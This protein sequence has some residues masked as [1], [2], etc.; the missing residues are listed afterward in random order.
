MISASANSAQA[1]TGRYRAEIEAGLAEYQK[2]LF[3]AQQETQG[4]LGEYYEQMIA[5]SKAA[6]EKEEWKRD[7]VSQ[8]W[9]KIGNAIHAISPVSGWFD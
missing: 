8:D 2:N 4:K 6:V 5:A 1:A 3:S 9:Y 7:P